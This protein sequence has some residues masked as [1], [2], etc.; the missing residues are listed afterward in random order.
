MKRQDWTLNLLDVSKPDGY[1]VN[2]PQTVAVGNYLRVA[3]R[4]SESSIYHTVQHDVRVTLTRG[5]DLGRQSHANECVIYNEYHSNGDKKTICLVSGI[6]PELMMSAQP[7]YW[8]DVELLPTGHIQDSL[9]R[10]IANMT[11][12]P[13]G[14]IRKAM[15]R[16]ARTP[17]AQALWILHTR[18]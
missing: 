14:L 16:R 7:V 3:K 15:P 12:D 6:M 17:I 18:L 4:L 2:F 8:S 1:Y 5:T 9:A 11:G 10:V 13:T